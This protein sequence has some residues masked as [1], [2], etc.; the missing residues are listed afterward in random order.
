MMM[1]MT[2]VTIKR[3]RW[4]DCHGPDHHYHHT[5]SVSP[6]IHPSSTA[7][8]PLGFLSLIILSPLPNGHCRRCIV[9]SDEHTS[10]LNDDWFIII[11]II[12][13]VVSMSVMSSG[14][15]IEKKKASSRPL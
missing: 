14:V 2:K 8:F 15:G 13:A 3:E 5:A 10:A 1:K 7:T 4:G 9:T 12:I 11:I 6:P